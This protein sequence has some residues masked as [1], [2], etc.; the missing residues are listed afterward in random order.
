MLGRSAH[1]AI[2]MDWFQCFN[3]RKVSPMSEPAARIACLWQHE[4]RPRLEP[5]ARKRS[6]DTVPPAKPKPADSRS[7][8][9]FDAMRAKPPRHRSNH[10]QVRA[11][12]NDLLGAHLA[13]RLAQYEATANPE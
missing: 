3:C 9:R 5:S 4:W 2:A 1:V 11:A 12:L 6:C 13:L 8:S 10:Q 7:T